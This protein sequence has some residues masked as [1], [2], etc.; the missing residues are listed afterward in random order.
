MV[1]IKSGEKKKRAI[2]EAAK[3]LFYEKGYKD[4]TLSDIARIVDC[5]ASSISYHFGSK[6]ELACLIQGEY[7]RQN[8]V[9]MEAITGNKYSKTMLMC[10]ELMEMWHRNFENA[11]LRRFLVETGEDSNI[12]GSYFENV[13]YLFQVV[14]DE[15]DVDISTES[16]DLIAATQIG[17]TKRLVD[18]VCMNPGKFEPMTIAEH[19]ITVFSKMVGIPNEKIEP[20]INN[21]KEI[22]P[23]LPID[24]RY[25]EYFQYKKEHILRVPTEKLP[26]EDRSI[27]D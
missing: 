18:I 25:F 12:L 10:L 17:M 13:K 23:S 15:H 5:P 3:T 2:L 8:K 1:E 9:Y 16:L 24:N 6:L 26:P 7:S 19:S 4:T 14:I 20:L 27:W 11:N 22:F 21:A